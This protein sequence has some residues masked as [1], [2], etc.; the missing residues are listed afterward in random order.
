MGTSMVLNDRGPQ[1]CRQQGLVLWKTALLR[2]EGVWF[3]DV[4]H[5]DLITKTPCMWNSQQGL[6]SY[7]NLRPPLIG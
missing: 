1:T 4:P 5:K 7:E 3:Q 6:Q 2:G